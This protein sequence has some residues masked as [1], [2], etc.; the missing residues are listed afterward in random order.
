MLRPDVLAFL[1]EHEW[2]ATTAELEELGVSRSA[3]TRARN[4]GLVTSPIHGMVV[5]GG[6]QL[7]FAGKM[8]LAVLGAGDEAFVSGQTAG[9]LHGLRG[10]STSKVEITVYERRRLTNHPSWCRIVRTSWIESIDV[11]VRDSDNLRIAS[12]LRTLFGLAAQFNQHHF[13][14][15]AEDLWH[16]GLAT[17]E[18]AWDYLQDI[19]RSGRTGVRTMETWL[20]KA[21]LRDRPAQSNLELDFIDIVERMGLPAP[22]RQHPVV[23]VTGETVHLDIA[24]PDLRLAVEPGHSWWHGGDLRQRRDQAR[25]RACNAVGWMVVRFDEEARRDLVAAGREV[26][27]IYRRRR[28]DSSES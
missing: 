28:A 14:R 18:Q 5:L 25:D 8:R 9:S 24:W 12:P 23:L 21:A 6:A 4:R 17:P 2:V 27:A 11:Q 15:A 13:E 20:E 3:L 22:K 1:A 10:M 7:T 26:V 16:R 19:R